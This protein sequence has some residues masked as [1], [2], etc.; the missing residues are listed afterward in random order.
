MCKNFIKGIMH[1]YLA[2]LKNLRQM[3]LYFTY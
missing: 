3:F 2:F 1:K